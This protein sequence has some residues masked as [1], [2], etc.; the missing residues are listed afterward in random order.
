LSEAKKKQVIAPG[1]LGWT[2]R[3]I[4]NQKETGVRGETAGGI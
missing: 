2:L 3:R 1:Q 4:Q